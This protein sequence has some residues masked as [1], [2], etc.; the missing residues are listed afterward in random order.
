MRSTLFADDD[1][2]VAGAE[3]VAVSA[4]CMRLVVRM[5]GDITGIFH[6]APLFVIVST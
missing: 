5:F 3:V 1:V 6:T 4:V 2:V